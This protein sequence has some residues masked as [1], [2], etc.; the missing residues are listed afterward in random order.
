MRVTLSATTGV[1]SAFLLIKEAVF[2]LSEHRQAT[3]RQ[4]L[5]ADPTCPIVFCREPE[6]ADL[7]F[8]FPFLCGFGA[9]VLVSLALAV[10]LRDLCSSLC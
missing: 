3:A 2:F 9:G 8:E 5:A 1:L 10:I 4:E 6:V 7:D